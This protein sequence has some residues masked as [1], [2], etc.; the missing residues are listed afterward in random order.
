MKA[1][2]WVVAAA[3]VAAPAASAGGAPTQQPPDAARLIADAF[4]L[5]YSLDFAGAL[6]KAHQAVAI[7]ASSAAA[8]RAVASIL[9]QQMLFLRGTVTVDDY[10]GSI[11]K[12]RASLPTLPPALTQEFSHEL[13]LAMSLAQTHVS[14]DKKDAAAQ[15]DLG[16]AYGL[17]ASYA[18]SVDGKDNAAFGPAR[19]A[20][21]AEETALDLAPSCVEAN[22]IVGTYRYIVS[23]LSLPV[24]WMAYVV[25]FGGGKEKGISMVEKAAS[26][27]SVRV[28]ASLALILIYSREKRYP[29]ALHV[30]RDLEAQFPTNRLFTLEE[31]ATL[32][33]MDRPQDA[34]AVLSAGIARLEADPRPK[35]PGEFALWH[36]KR[37]AARVAEGHN[38]E[39][40]A[41]LGTAMGSGPIG[42]V[43]GRVHVE[44]GKIADLNGDRARAL[45]EYREAVRLCTLNNDP[46]CTA[47]AQNRLKKSS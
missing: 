44:M 25:G 11:N 38:A 28:D 10:L 46:I 24:R 17:Q 13:G 18:A 26:A 23:T 19:H 4:T 30:V 6:A 29:D 45:G 5:S 33:R 43:L 22:L 2:A 20:F 8:H 40:I 9:W 12:S 31:G 3:L 37:G 15:Y 7:D 34:D 14:R 35:M 32:L 1:A 47:D 42:W 27:G 41:D 21:D 16:A 36:Y 39:A